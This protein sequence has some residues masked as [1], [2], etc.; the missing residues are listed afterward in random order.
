MQSL[1]QC[2]TCG[3]IKANLSIPLCNKCHG[4]CSV[5]W[6]HAGQLLLS[7][8]NYTDT[9]SAIPRE[10]IAIPN[11]VNQLNLMNTTESENSGAFVMQAAANFQ[12]NA[13]SVCLGL[14]RP[15]K[16]NSGLVKAMGT[17]AS[18]IREWKDKRENPSN[19]TIRLST[20]L[21]QMPEA[22]N[23]IRRKMQQVIVFFTFVTVQ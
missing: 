16:P 21:W 2:Q 12:Q 11:T 7:S 17:S 14:P 22:V 10:V 8:L 13:S 20:A 23:N 19:L 18:V 6:R 1:L 3:L 5:Y 4:Y 15:H 9:L